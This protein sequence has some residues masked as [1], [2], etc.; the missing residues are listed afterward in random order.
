MEKIKGSSQHLLSIIN[1]VLDM[2]KIESGKTVLN[3]SLIHILTKA[4]SRLVAIDSRRWIQFLL[5]ILPRLDDVDFTILSHMEQQMLNMFYTTV[6]QETIEDFGADEVWEKLYTL[7]DS[8]VMLQ[9][10]IRC[11]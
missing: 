3:L 8:P 6:W 11:V 4:F 5:D 2:S 10:L 9:E 7:C 1:D